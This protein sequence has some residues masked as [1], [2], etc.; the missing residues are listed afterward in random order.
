M[1]IMFRYPTPTDILA[2]LAGVFTALKWVF[3]GGSFVIFALA[4]LLWIAVKVNLV[5]T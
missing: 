2:S 4:I 1:V 3:V 5:K